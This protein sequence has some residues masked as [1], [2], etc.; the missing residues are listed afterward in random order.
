MPET[1]PFETKMEKKRGEKRKIK[2][3][4]RLPLDLPVIQS[5]LNLLGLLFVYDFSK[6]KI[7][8]S[9]GFYDIY[10]VKHPNE[11]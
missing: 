5:H 6:K 8:I 1:F 9:R 11:M 3:L 4:R 7:I 10:N 2:T